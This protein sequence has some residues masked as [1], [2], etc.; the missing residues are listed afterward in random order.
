MEH[1]THFGFKEIDASS[2]EPMVK[3]VF[4][5]VASS[6]DLMNDVMSLC[7]HR[8]WKQRML[9]LLVDTSKSLLDVAG[10]TGDI[11]RKYYHKAKLAN[12][13]PYI[14]ACDI[15]HAMLSVGRDKLIDENMPSIIKFICANAEK[16]PFNDMSF[17]YYTIAFGIR[18]VTNIDLALSE[19][20]RVLKPGGKFICLEFSHPA[21]NILSKAYDLYSFNVIPLLGK[22]IA[23]NAEA[24]QYLVESIRK[25]PGA[26]KFS[27]MIKDSGFSNVNHILLSG[28][29]TAIH[30][31]YKV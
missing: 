20:H 23:N 28:G 14:A 25:F 19:A 10:G 22:I 3:Q 16:L 7:I 11:A 6:Y 13:Q 12:H 4:S 5:S 31:G 29:I 2:K 27:A 15:N 17:G 8:L 30:Y 21:N 18:N 1:K 26:G 9:E 24:Y